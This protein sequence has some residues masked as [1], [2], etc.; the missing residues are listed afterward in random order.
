MIEAADDVRDYV[1]CYFCQKR[2][3]DVTGL[4]RYLACWRKD[5]PEADDKHHKADAVRTIC[6]HE[7]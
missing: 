6:D 2:M 7:G 1:I 5:P 4:K 3:Q